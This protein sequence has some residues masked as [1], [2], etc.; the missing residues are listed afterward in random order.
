M[1]NLYY[2]LH[3]HK[4]SQRDVSKKSWQIVM[5]E[6][7]L[8]KNNQLKEENRCIVGD[9]GLFSSNINKFAVGKVNPTIETFKRLVY[10]INAILEERGLVKR[11][12]YKDL[13]GDLEE[14]K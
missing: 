7:K 3:S 8:I 10:V 4:I 13:I 2:I 9:H 12:R 6:N 1:T 14:D 5:A 11:Y